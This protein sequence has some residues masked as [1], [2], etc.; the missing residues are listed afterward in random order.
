MKLGGALPVDAPKVEKG[1]LGAS[2]CAAPK[3]PDDC[4]LDDCGCCVN[5]LP[6]FVDPALKT[7]ELPTVDAGVD[8]G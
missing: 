4:V 6:V 5:T 2:G 7:V 8:E 3:I 1:F